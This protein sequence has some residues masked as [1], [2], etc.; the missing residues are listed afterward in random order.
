MKGNSELTL[1]TIK[2]AISNATMNLME[3]LI[4]AQD[5]HWRHA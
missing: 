3:S 5:E 4:M 2:E 1:S